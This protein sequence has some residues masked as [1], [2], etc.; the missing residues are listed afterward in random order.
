MAMYLMWFASVAND[1]NDDDIDGQWAWQRVANKQ[2][3]IYA[4][5]VMC[6][7]NKGLQRK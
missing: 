1:D 4:V 5:Y 2:R 7:S 3:C 6:G